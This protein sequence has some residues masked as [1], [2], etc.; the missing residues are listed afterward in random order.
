MSIPSQF[1]VLLDNIKEAESGKLHRNKNE[2]DVTNGWGVYRGKGLGKDFEPLWEYID[3]VAKNVTDKSSKDWT[4]D[5]IEKI[6]ALLDKSTEEELSYLFYTEYFKNAHLDLFHK[7]LVI[8]M[9]NLYTN[10]P[11]GAWMSVQ[12]GL[13]DIVKDSI[14]PIPLKDTSIVD[15]DFGDKTR[16]ALVKFLEIADRKDVIIF[17]KSILLAMKSYYMDLAIGNPDKFLMYLNG[18]DNRIEDLE[19]K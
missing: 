18:W 11:K 3:G 10:S 4:K 15:G 7:D 1:Q 8:L 14:L 6:E 5:D 12:E 9:A 19:H 2:L 16:K 13:R 17:K